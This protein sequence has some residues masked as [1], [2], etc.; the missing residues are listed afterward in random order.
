MSKPIVYIVDDNDFV[1]ES[2][3]NLL[4]VCLNV[5]VEA[6]TSGKEFLDKPSYGKG[7][8]LI[9]D[10]RM[11]N[12]SGSEVIDE[13]VRRKYSMPTILISGHTDEIPAPSEQPTFVKK[14]LEKP[15]DTKELIS[16][17]NTLIQ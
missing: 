1:R 8:C 6:F 16:V 9:L 7:A 17:L 15:Y 12:M 5:N 14:F 10:H 2:L 13:L 11:P 3:A 4:E